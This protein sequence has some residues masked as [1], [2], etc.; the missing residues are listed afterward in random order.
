MACSQSQLEK[1]VN[2]TFNFLTLIWMGVLKGLASPKKREKMFYMSTVTAL[3]SWWSH[4]F[5]WQ[6]V[7]CHCFQNVTLSKYKKTKK[8]EVILWWLSDTILWDI[9]LSFFYI[10]F[11]VHL[12]FLFLQVSASRFVFLVRKAMFFFFCFF[13]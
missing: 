13:F 8:S 3:I 4:L 1:V 7:R 10:F 2:T 5:M 9:F 6:F 11:T 12:G